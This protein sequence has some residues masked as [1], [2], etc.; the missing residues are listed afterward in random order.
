MQ[1]IHKLLQFYFFFVLKEAEA[2][3]EKNIIF[4]LIYSK[5]FKVLNWTSDKKRKKKLMKWWG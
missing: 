1:L 2:E 5:H 4:F 3:A